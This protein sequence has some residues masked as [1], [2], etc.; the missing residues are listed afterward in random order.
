MISKNEILKREVK[1]ETRTPWTPRQNLWHHSQVRSHHRPARGVWPA[2]WSAW[3]GSPLLKQQP[4]RSPALMPG[5][6]RMPALPRAVFPSPRG[7]TI[8][9][10]QPPQELNDR[11]A[12][13][14]PSYCQP[15]NVT[16]HTRYKSSSRPITQLI[17]W[18]ISF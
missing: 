3:T 9:R 7:P 12:A 1:E 18:N 14:K 5:S 4:P 10:P 16:I 13:T 17:I 6:V 8:H 11:W 2:L 15:L